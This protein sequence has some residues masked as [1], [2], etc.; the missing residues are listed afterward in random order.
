MRKSTAI[1]A[2]ALG[3]G[4]SPLAMAA[5]GVNYGLQHTANAVELPKTYVLSQTA[6][7]GTVDIG[8]APAAASAPAGAGSAAVP[9]PVKLYSTLQQAAQDQHA[10]PLV[11]QH[12]APKQLTLPTAVTASGHTGMLLVV[13]I[14]AVLLFVAKQKH[15]T[16]A[17][18]DSDKS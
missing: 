5:P 10:A 18:T 11:V 8:S 9:G 1:S 14:A 12:S 13:G 17:P 7:P 2:L 4:L 15:R 16:K 3:A 6:E